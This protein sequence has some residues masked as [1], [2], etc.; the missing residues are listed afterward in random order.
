M[1]VSPSFEL[2][3]LFLG[4]ALTI[5]ALVTDMSDNFEAAEWETWVKLGP[6]IVFIL[7]V[8]FGMIGHFK[9]S[10][11]TLSCGTIGTIIGLLLTYFLAMF[12]T[13]S[14]SQVVCNEWDSVCLEDSVG[15]CDTDYEPYEAL[16][17]LLGI[18]FF[19]IGGSLTT[20]FFV[21]RTKETKQVKSS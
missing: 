11:G 5:P 10:S 20:L 9:H 4:F 3:M 8:S 7:S 18:V 19:I 1:K 6:H 21:E 14:V 16:M 13:R 12:N 2:F 17:Y 15:S